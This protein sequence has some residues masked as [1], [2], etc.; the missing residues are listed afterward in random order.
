MFQPHLH[1]KLLNDDLTLRASRAPIDLVRTR[2]SH[3]L[4]EIRCAGCQEQ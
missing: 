1:W 3:G 2:V 4:P